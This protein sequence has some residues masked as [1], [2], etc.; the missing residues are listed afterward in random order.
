MHPENRRAENVRT[1][2]GAISGLIAEARIRHEALCELQ[3]LYDLNCASYW[4]DR[5]QRETADFHALTIGAPRIK[6]LDPLHLIAE[7]DR[8]RPRGCYRETVEA[9]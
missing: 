8:V 4:L 7:I 1:F 2:K 5:R 6:I 3:E 9:P